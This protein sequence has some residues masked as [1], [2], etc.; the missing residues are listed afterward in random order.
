MNCTAKQEARK[1]GRPSLVMPEL[2]NDTL[3]NVA[4]AILLTP[5]KK[6]SEWRLMQR[7]EFGHNWPAQLAAGRE[8]GV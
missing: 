5:P 3:E 1:V 4:K 7:K 2:I 8:G 6:R